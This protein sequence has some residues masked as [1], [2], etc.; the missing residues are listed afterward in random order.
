[1]DLVPLHLHLTKCIKIEKV[2]ITSM[3]KRS[4][5]MIDKNKLLFEEWKQGN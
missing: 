4:T 2:K 1:M 3:E 5:R